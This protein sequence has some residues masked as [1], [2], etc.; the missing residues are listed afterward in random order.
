MQDI[1]CQLGRSRDKPNT[2]QST[3]ATRQAVLR[4]PLMAAEA[5]QRAPRCH[6]LL[7]MHLEFQAPEARQFALLKDR[8]HFLDLK[9]L[10]FWEQGLTTFVDAN[11]WPLDAGMPTWSVHLMRPVCLQRAPLRLPC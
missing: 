9:P 6:S 10:F 5:Q 1:H 2:W 8:H 11:Q 4:G 3:V 7:W